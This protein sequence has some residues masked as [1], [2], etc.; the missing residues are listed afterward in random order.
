MGKTPQILVTACL[1]Y[2]V[3]VACSGAN[4]DGGALAGAAGGAGAAGTTGSAGAGLGIEVPDA[5]AAGSAGAATACDCQPRQPVVVTG[6]CAAGPTMGVVNCVGLFPGKTAIE[7]SQV[8]AMVDVSGCVYP[9][10]CDSVR[11]QNFSGFA[12][13]KYI[14]PNMVGVEDG[15]VTAMF[16][17]GVTS[18]TFILP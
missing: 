8:R 11:Q 18:A 17:D 5:S 13:I 15:K 6:T 12:T 9:D 10:S 3:A 1:G 16:S 14:V 4:L 2:F 7:L